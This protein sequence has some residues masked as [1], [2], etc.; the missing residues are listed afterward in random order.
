MKIM[1]LS[2]FF[3]P[4]H[5]GGAEL[6]AFRLAKK[7]QDKG[8]DI[9]VFSTCQKKEEAG[10]RFV[11]GLEVLFLYSDYNLKWRGWRGVNNPKVLSELKKSI[12]DFKP[13]IIHV[14]NVHSY[15][16]Y[17]VL[18]LAKKYCQRVFLTVHDV[19]SFH[20]DKFSNYIDKNNL[21]IIE[22]FNY[23]LSIIEKL[24]QLKKTLNPFRNFLINRYSKS[25]NKILAVS[26]ALKDALN[27]NK[28]TNV[29]VVYNGVDSGNIISN[30]KELA[31][32]RFN[33]SRESRVI[34]MAGRFGSLKGGNLI[35]PYIK[36]LRK[37]SND[38]IFVIA[39]QKTNYVKTILNR[40]E[41][42]GLSRYLLFTGWLKFE[43]LNLLYSRCDLCL[44]PSI[45]FDSFPNNNLEAMSFKKPV[46]GTCFG[47]TPEAVI[48]NQTGYIINPLNISD[49]VSKIADLLFNQE[50]AEQFGITGYNRVKNEFSLDGQVDQYLDYFND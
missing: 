48:D 50:R 29:E 6:I 46:I 15:I 35:I 40:A 10:K 25:A 12:N 18:K 45:C 4:F 36:E 5:G 39:S 30:N 3:P 47:G 31:E 8:N 9:L 20:Q 22:K 49:T 32:K 37:I 7:F 11:D 41:K 28:I 38:F 1:I 27:Q 43:D 19:D 24:R 2:D 34:L 26:Q 42:E 17:A 23:R 14:H 33:I 16:S 44:V 21:S 13:D